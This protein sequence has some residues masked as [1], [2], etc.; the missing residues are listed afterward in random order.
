MCQKRLPNV[1]IFIFF[2]Y[3]TTETLLQTTTRLQ[4]YH[5][6]CAYITQ[7]DSTDLN[8]ICHVQPDKTSTE[9]D[10]PMQKQAVPYLIGYRVLLNLPAMFICLILGNWS[11][12]NGRKG[13]MIIPVVG[14]CLACGLFGGSLISGH[15]AIPFQMAWLL[16][17]AFLYGL[18]GKSN[19]FGMG[20]HSYITDCSSE[21]ERT[22]RIGRLLGINF[23]GLCIGSLLVAFFYYL[24]SYGWVLLFVIVFNIAILVILVFVVK[25]SVS[26][27]PLD[28]TGEYGTLNTVELD[29]RD[30]NEDCIT[31]G[32]KA[33]GSGRVMMKGVS[34]IYK[35]I[36][37]SLTES[38]LYVS[39]TRPN[40]RHIYIRILLGAVLF[41][42]VTK[43]GE[44]DSLLLFLVRRDIGWTD[45]IYGAYQATYYASMAINLVIVLPIIDYLFHPSDIFLILSGLLMKTIR[46]IA[47][48]LTT[49]TVLIFVYAIL[50]S[51]AG[52]IISS[53]RSMIT[54]LVD[55]GEVGTSFALMSVLETF[56][57]LFGSILFTSIYAAT[58][59]VFPGAVFIIDACLHIGMIV[60]MSWLGLRLK[61]MPV[62]E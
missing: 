2:I 30:N 6:V 21:A 44:Q 10:S 35:T 43:A 14:A 47:T 5:L 19:A 36:R 59:S 40:E 46:L 48:A 32:E 13:P 26:V 60:L 25:E 27:E 61:I 37:T 17:G 38:W 52:F 57:N 53:L 39:K 54:K 23:F 22:T 9:P 31:G 50:G 4:V 42:Q 24:S 56:A 20:A 49:D 62:S 15:P 11:D 16:T 55:S 18:C 58:L 33:S 34:G 7:T 28:N 51:S 12:L 1:V 41:N 3:K 8:S 45:G 29:S